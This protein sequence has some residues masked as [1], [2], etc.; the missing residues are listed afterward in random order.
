M[1][2]L[3]L[4]ALAAGCPAATRAPTTAA[5]PSASSAVPLSVA[6]APAP[7]SLP[8]PPPLAP[9]PIRVVGYPLTVSTGMNDPADV[10]GFTRD[11]AEYGYCNTV[12]AR[13]PA[14]THCDFVRRD[15]THHLFDSDDDRG[16]VP[17]KQ[18]ALDAWVREQGVPKLDFS[19][20]PEKHFA[21]P[22]RGTWAFS[23]ITIWVN[24]VQADG[25][26]TNAVVKL[27]GVVAGEP[28]VY[29]VVLAAKPLGP[30]M[31][32]HTSIMND[33]S[34]SPDGTEIG[35]VG[36]FFCAEW[37]DAFQ[38]Y[39]AKV[40]AFASLVYN[41]AGFARH[42]KHDWARAAELFLEA[43]AADP[44]AKL[45]PY[46]LACA[47]ARLG[48]ARAKDALAA[49]IARDPGAKARATKDA[50]FAGVRDQKWFVDLVK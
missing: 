8:A 49:A 30:E 26:K 4:L 37:C 50:D 48:D 34:L 28:V 38:V 46:N 47:W 41:D 29:P 15:G 35:A 40:G 31:K 44:S 25:V 18:K 13:T 16:F 7:A 33:L 12:E 32:Y 5:S 21:R 43:A 17:A 27:G 42:E 14:V 6:S 10:V 11:G 20:P 2:A 36:H 22:L 19:G 1:R 45:P 39:R 3:F 24:P 9:A 23:D